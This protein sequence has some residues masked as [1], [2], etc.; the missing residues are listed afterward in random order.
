MRKILFSFL[1]VHTSILSLPLSIVFVLLP[2]LSS[3][4]H[5]LSIS[6][7]F[8]SPFHILSSYCLSSH[9]PLTSAR[10][11]ISVLSFLIPPPPQ[12]LLWP[13]LLIILHAYH[14]LPS[15]IPPLPPSSPHSFPSSHLFHLLL[16]LSSSSSTSNSQFFTP[17][18]LYIQY[19]SFRLT[20]A[21]P[22]GFHPS[23]SLSNFV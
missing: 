6:F 21:H 18:P 2:T 10:S 14:P 5:Y 19:F 11:L 9:H 3:S 4:I 7:R 8:P 20:P 12:L 13:L 15:V 22:T 1:S 16:T 17:Y 23:P